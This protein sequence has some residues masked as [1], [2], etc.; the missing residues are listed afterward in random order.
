MGRIAAILM[1]VLTPL[2]CYSLAQSN[3]DANWLFGGIVIAGFATAL[4]LLFIGLVAV[5]L[6]FRND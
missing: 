3:P 1:L 4:I 6:G 2:L 5:A